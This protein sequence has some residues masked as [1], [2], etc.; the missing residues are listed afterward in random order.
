MEV[1]LNGNHI[2]VRPWRKEGWYI[3]AW[4]YARKVMNNEKEKMAENPHFKSVRQNIVSSEIQKDSGKLDQ[5][6]QADKQGSNKKQNSQ[7]RPKSKVEI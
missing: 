1:N 4:L 7:H 2:G 5:T 6:E 3:I